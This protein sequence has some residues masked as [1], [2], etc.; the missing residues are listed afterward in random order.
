MANFMG[1]KL[2]RLELLEMGGMHYDEPTRPEREIP[3]A[4]KLTSLELAL[5]E[6]AANY[7][8]QLREALK[9]LFLSCGGQ[10]LVPSVFGMVVL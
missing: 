2:S 8:G 7:C 1:S 10:S 3:V 9:S 6:Q 5:W 4:W